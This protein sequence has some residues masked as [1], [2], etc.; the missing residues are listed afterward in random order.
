MT[1]SPPAARRVAGRPAAI[2]LTLLALVGLAIVQTCRLNMVEGQL[3]AERAR[4]L[5]NSVSDMAILASECQRQL[6]E[7]A[8]RDKLYPLT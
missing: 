7:E 6:E 1:T 4:R 2:T 8:P 3:T 5:A